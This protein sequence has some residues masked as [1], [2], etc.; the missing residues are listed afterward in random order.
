VKSSQ[1]NS[2]S[3]SAASAKGDG[4]DRQH[5]VDLAGF[6]NPMLGLWQFQ[7]VTARMLLMRQNELLDF[8]SHRCAQDLQLVDQIAAVKAPDALTGI[9]G[10]FYSNTVRE[11]YAEMGRAVDS[12]PLSVTLAGEATRASAKRVSETAVHARS[13]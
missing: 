13:A 2:K 5:S 11:Y 10:N 6:S 7:A 1:N 3:H 12:A 8:L 9:I 4:I